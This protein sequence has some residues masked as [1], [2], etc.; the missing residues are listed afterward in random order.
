MM[1][2]YMDF[3][4]RTN[5]GLTNCTYDT[6]ISDN[7]RDVTNVD[8]FITIVKKLFSKANFDPCISITSDFTVTKGRIFEDWKDGKKGYTFIHFGAKNGEDV[9]YWR[10]KLTTAEIK[11]FYLNCVE[12]I[13]EA[14]K[15]A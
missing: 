11:V 2:L 8:Y 7:Y 5:M 13:M 6:T 1:K 15:V 14:E 10:E 3:R 9:T 12:K 4:T